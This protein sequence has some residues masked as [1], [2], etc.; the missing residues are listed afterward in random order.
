[1]NDPIIHYADEEF[2]VCPHMRSGSNTKIVNGTYIKYSSRCEPDGQK[3]CTLY[4]S[5][6]SETKT[7]SV[8]FLGDIPKKCPHRLV[9]VDSAMKEI[10]ETNTLTLN[11][12]RIAA[13][14][15]IDGIGIEVFE[16]DTIDNL[17]R[18]AVAEIG[19]LRR[20][21][22]QDDETKNRLSERIRVLSDIRSRVDKEN[23]NENLR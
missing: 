4:D 6:D 3:S 14:I 22:L 16:F 10:I 8:D 11:R 2:D 9:A 19:K 7:R 23:P 20:R 18:R 21:H 12:C 5:I 13:Q 1:M 15:L 17:A